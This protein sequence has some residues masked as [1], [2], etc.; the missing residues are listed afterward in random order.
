MRFRFAIAVRDLGVCP[1]TY[2]RKVTVSPFL[3]RAL[4]V[5]GRRVGFFATFLAGLL[6]L[7]SLISSW[8]PFEW[9]VLS[10]SRPFATG[11]APKLDSARFPAA[12]KTQARAAQR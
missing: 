8:W 1:A 7:L 6:I 3:A 10:G 5:A 11:Y 12:L 2:K 9:R 4:V